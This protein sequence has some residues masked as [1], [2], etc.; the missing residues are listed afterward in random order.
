MPVEVKPE[1]VKSSL[2]LGPDPLSSVG[3]Y[4]VNFQGITYTPTREATL[5][6][7]ARRFPLRPIMSQNVA[8]WGSCFVVKHP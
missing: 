1:T 8:L 5:S 6:L 4:T 3:T 7:T 2:K